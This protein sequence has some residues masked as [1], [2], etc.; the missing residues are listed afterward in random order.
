MGNSPSLLGRGTA[1][2]HAVKITRGGG[3]ASLIAWGASGASATRG[4]LTSA[5]LVRAKT[6]VK[7]WMPRQNAVKISFFLLKKNTLG[8][9]QLS[10]VLMGNV[11]CRGWNAPNEKPQKIREVAHGAPRWGLSPSNVWRVQCP[12]C[13]R[14]WPRAHCRG[15]KM[16]PFTDTKNSKNQ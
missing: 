15:M 7:T 13:M 1:M 4:G 12:C 5:S 6:A 11:N 14:S 10:S 16:H 9:C 2:Q 8:T 3:G